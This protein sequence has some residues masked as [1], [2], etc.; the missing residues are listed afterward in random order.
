[1]KTLAPFS[2]LPFSKFYLRPPESLR[3]QEI[4]TMSK[5][6]EIRVFAFSSKI[7]CTGQKGLEIFR[8]NLAKAVPKS[9]CFFPYGE[10]FLFKTFLRLF[11]DGLSILKQ[12][13]LE[14]IES[15][16]L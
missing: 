15:I 2:L 6:F 11:L 1:L 12:R 14:V 4:H 10:G 16:L 7:I 5:Q 8:R 3:I 13:I 9:S